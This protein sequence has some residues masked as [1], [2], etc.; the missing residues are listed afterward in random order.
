MT[1]RPQ[2][3]LID[4]YLIGEASPAERA[5]VQAWIDA[6]PRREVALAWLRSQHDAA[7]PTWNAD[8]AWTRFAGRPVSLP[9]PHSKFGMSGPESHGTLATPSRRRLSP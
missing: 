4:A 1:D 5:A 7:E 9:A 8:A 3:S 6:Q 2:W